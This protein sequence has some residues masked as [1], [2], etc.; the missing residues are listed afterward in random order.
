MSAFNLG[1][2]GASE[3]EFRCT[4]CA[5]LWAFCGLVHHVFH[6]IFAFASLLY[7][8]ATGNL[9]AYQFTA[10]LLVLRQSAAS[11]TVFTVFSTCLASNSAMVELRNVN[12]PLINFLFITK[13]NYCLKNLNECTNKAT[14]LKRT[15]QV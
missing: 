9:L 10:A 3:T 7:A 15:Y 2:T 4:R 12:L 11:G 8:V 6:Y 5:F 13:L 1:G 14:T